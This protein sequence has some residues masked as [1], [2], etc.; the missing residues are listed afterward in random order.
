[1]SL[2]VWTALAFGTS[3]SGVLVDIEG[4]PVSN[5]TAVAYDQRMNYGFAFS[6][7][8]GSYIIADLPPNPYRVRILPDS[9]DNLV[10]QWISSDLSLC[11]S[12]VYRVEDPVSG[13]DA[14]LETGI[15]ISGLIQDSQGLPVVNG[16]VA[17]RSIEAV[18]PAASR[19]SATSL[20]GEFFIRG[21][22][23][24]QGDS[25][26]FQLIVQAE[27]WPDQYLPGVYDPEEAL[28]ISVDKGGSADAGTIQL[29]DGIG[30]GGT[31]YGPDGALAQGNVS[32]YS[33]SQVI[34]AP[35]V[36]GEYE[37]LGLPAGEVLVWASST[38]MA[39]TY[40]PNSDRPDE[41]VLVAEEGEFAEGL[42]LELPP[43]SRI[44]GQIEGEGDFSLA[45]VLVYNDTRTVGFGGSVEPDGSFIVSNLHGAQ[46]FV[47]FSAAK[48]GYLNDYLRD[49]QGEQR[50]F[51]VPDE[52]DLDLTVTL[53]RGATVLGRVTDASTGEPVYGATIFGVGM[54]SEE[55]VVAS[56]DQN[57]EWKI[58]GL[59]EDDWEFYI[60]YNSF[61]SAD[62]D[63]VT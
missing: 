19:S 51:T 7:Q 23:P 44:I 45:S 27:G 15:I 55:S 20:T 47:H 46:Y 33:P 63:W 6:D 49:E 12:E 5:A 22:P 59:K 38:D 41:R 60:S 42:D 48:A 29:L 52:G 32:A 25:G 16:K 14:I 54:V 53:T 2:L 31:I 61:C 28:L 56:S 11:D 21:L 18:A 39:T 58:M 10:E 57:G 40:Y 43:Q 34:T 30:V 62:P 50:L 1:M 17:T 24:E 9:S 8:E 4:N 26:T 13:A 37:I 3:I 35:I 36:N